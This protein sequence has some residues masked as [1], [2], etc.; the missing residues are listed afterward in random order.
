MKIYLNDIG[1]RFEI[2]TGVDVTAATKVGLV[3]KKPD[4]TV[5]N[6][7]GHIDTTDPLQKN[8]VIYV[9][10]IGDFDQPGFY[11]AQA[12]VTFT[13]WSGRGE[14]FTFQVNDYFN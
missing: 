11:I 6:W 8:N 7:A 1:T 4:G 14:A 3:V 2:D 5:V 9:A 10:G 12:T 13:N